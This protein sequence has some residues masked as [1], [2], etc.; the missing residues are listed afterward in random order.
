LVAVIWYENALPRVPL[1][2][3]AP[4]ITGA[5]AAIVNVR[6]AWPA[7][8]ELVALNVTVEAPA[9]VGVPEIK[10]VAVFTDNTE[11]NPVAP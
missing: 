4:V 11:G 5:G 1:S 3:V 10:P 8:A 9:A 2:V 7:P 6:A